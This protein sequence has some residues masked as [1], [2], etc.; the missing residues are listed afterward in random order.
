M[1]ERERY[2][3]TAGGPGAGEGVGVGKK[4]KK[5]K[6]RKVF[7]R[8]SIGTFAPC[9]SPE[10]SF[11]SLFI[12][13]FLQQ[14]SSTIDC[15][16]VWSRLSL[17]LFVTGI[18]NKNRKQKAL[19]KQNRKQTTTSG[20][21]EI[22]MRLWTSYNTYF[23]RFKPFSCVRFFFCLRSLCCCPRLVLGIR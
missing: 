16:G 14:L 7:A 20:Q 15:S 21:R 19:I 18:K 17:T 6:K 11:F 2:A 5:K 10:T 4:A 22:S 9:S 8:A 23:Q 13:P 3:P 12:I 1:L